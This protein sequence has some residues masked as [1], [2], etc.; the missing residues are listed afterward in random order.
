[1]SINRSVPEQDGET[2]LHGGDFVLAGRSV[3]LRIPGTERVLHIRKEDGGAAVDIYVGEEECA[4]N[5][6]IASF[7][8]PG[9][10]DVVQQTV[11]GL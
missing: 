8:V 9:Y 11:G 3:W 2:E 7:Y 6:P 10:S 4:Q 5:E 1:M